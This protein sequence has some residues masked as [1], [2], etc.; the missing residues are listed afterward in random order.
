MSAL[1]YFI[2]GGRHACLAA[3]A[4]T[5]AFPEVVI[6]KPTSKTSDRNIFI[7]D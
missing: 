7:L 4:N 3:S 2:G 5:E 1:E 6:G